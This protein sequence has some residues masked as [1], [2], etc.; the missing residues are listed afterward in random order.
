MIENHGVDPDIK[1]ATDPGQLMAGHDAQLQAAV[2]YLMG[3]LKAKPGGLP[4]PPPP[5]PAYPP[6][7]RVP[8]THL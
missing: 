6:A 8:P 7:G 4:A 3:L 5:L 1:V 2:D